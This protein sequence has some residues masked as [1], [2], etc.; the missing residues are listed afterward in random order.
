M[1]KI[2]LLPA[3]RFED[4][5]KKHHKFFILCVINIPAK[6]EINGISLTQALMRKIV[7]LMLSGQLNTVHNPLFLQMKT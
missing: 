5:D 3:Y 6:L 1:I 2:L 7:L 4:R